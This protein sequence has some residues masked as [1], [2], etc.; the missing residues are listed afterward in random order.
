MRVGKDIVEFEIDKGRRQ[1]EGVGRIERIEDLALELLPRRLV[2]LA[3]QLLGD[4]AA[5]GKEQPKTG[6]DGPGKKKLRQRETEGTRLTA[7]KSTKKPAKR[8]PK[9]GPRNKSE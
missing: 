9:R 1:L 4:E 6:V 3:F 2:V 5:P 8:A 7:G